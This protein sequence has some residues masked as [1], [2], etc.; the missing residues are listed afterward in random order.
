MTHLITFK[1]IEHSF[2]SNCILKRADLQLQTRDCVLLTG[3]NGAGKSSLLKIMAGLLRPDHAHVQY[4]GAD[5]SWPQAKPHLRQDVIYL[6]QH[7]YL[8]NGSVLDNI[9]YG[10]NRLGMDRQT[11]REKVTEALNWAELEHLALR[12]ARTLSGGEKQRVA[13]TR[14][15][16]LSPRLLLLDEPTASMD[17]ESKQQTGFMLR[18]LKSE[19]V[20]CIIS[21]HEAQTIQKIADRHL[22]LADGKLQEHTPPRSAQTHIDPPDSLD[23][24]S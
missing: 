22:L 2:G 7:P 18:R 19:G 14:A 17:R 16:I 13:L 11:I 8:F 4:L 9:A 10:L 1:S 5:M 24:Q 6:H 23:M 3:R 12:Q 21:S 15:R 20:T